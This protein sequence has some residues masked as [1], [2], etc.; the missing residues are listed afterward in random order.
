M[1]ARRRGVNHARGDQTSGFR[2]LAVFIEII[3]FIVMRRSRAGAGCEAANFGIL[4]SRRRRSRQE[5]QYPSPEIFKYAIKTK[6]K[7][8]M[9]G[10]LLLINKRQHSKTQRGSNTGGNA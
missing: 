3:A 6:P 10:D 5:S 1:T 8:K 2:L 9:R 4:T 7:G